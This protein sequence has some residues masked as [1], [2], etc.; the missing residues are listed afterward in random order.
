VKEVNAGCADL[1]LSTHLL[2]LSLYHPKE[3]ALAY[4]LPTRQGPDLALVSPTEE[5]EEILLQ[6]PQFVARDIYVEHL[7]LRRE[8]RLQISNSRVAVLAF[9]WIDLASEKA[10]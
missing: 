3:I 5:C 10:H 1:S 7:A 6:F 8:W 9:G 2:K 4:T